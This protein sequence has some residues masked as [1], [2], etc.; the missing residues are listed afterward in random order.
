[1]GRSFLSWRSHNGTGLKGKSRQA[2]LTFSSA[3]R[4]RKSRIEPLESREML[5]AVAQGLPSP[6]ATEAVVAD[7]PITGVPQTLTGTAGVPLGKHAGVGFG[8][9]IAGIRQDISAGLQ[10]FGAVINWG[11]GPVT[12][13]DAFLDLSLASDTQ[14]RT[15]SVFA[16]HTYTQLGTYPITVVFSEQGVLEATVTSTAIISGTGN[17]QFVDQVYR[18]LLGRQPDADGLAVWLAQLDQGMPRNQFVAQI[19]QSAEYRQDQVTAIY[20]KYLHRPA[21]P[22]GLEMG[23]RLLAHGASDEQVAEIVVGSQEYFGL[24]G[25]TDDAFLAAL[26][27]DALNRPIDAGAKAAFG[28]ALAAGASRAQ[29]AEAVFSS[30]EYHN[31]VV[32]DVYLRLLHRHADTAGQSFWTN[33]LDAGNTDEQLMAALAASDEYFGRSA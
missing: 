12:N 6:Q 1:M 26:F 33:W 23:G 5:T 25:G 9:V 19:E 20:Q 11:D 13:G 4:L 17:Q 3:K 2:S 22:A 14:H 27:Q 21:D 10:T 8:E 32:D 18:D 28:Q 16:A 15:Y 30:R 29:I 7:Q 24:H 31:D